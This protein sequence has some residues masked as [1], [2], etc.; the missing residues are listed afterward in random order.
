MEKI[1]PIYKKLLIA[2]IVLYITGVTFILAD[3]YMKVGEIEHAL[4]HIPGIHQHNH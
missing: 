4:I 2:A 1:R 3:L